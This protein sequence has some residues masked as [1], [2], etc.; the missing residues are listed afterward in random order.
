M[1]TPRPPYPPRTPRVSRPPGPQESPLDARFA[2]AAV[3]LKHFDANSLEGDWGPTGSVNR[4]TF[5]AKISP[6][7][8]ATSYLPAFEIAVRSGRALGVMCSYNAINGVPSCASRSLLG[9]T[10]RTEWNFSGYVT[11]PFTYIY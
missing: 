2:Q 11:I 6:H 7:D 3:T 8:L 10:L 1:R 9:E 5:D 4:H